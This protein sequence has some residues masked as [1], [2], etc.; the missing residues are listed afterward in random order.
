MKVLVAIDCSPVLER[1]LDEAAGHGQNVASRPARSRLTS[2]PQDGSFRLGQRVGGRRDS[3]PM[4]RRSR[5]E[6]VHAKEDAMLLAKELQVIAQSP[7]P[8][9][10][11][12]VNTRTQNASR[13]PRVPACLAWLRKE[14][15]SISRT[16]R[17]RDAE[18]FLQEVQRIVRFL[19]DRR[20]E[21]K[22]LAI[23]SGPKTWTIFPMHIAVENELAW[24]QPGIGQLFRLLHEHKSC[25][26]VAVDH[27][28]ARF[29]AYS[30]GELTELARK[31]FEVDPS[32]WKKKSLGHV[33]SDR[34][35]KMRGPHPDRFEHRMGTQ[36]ARL[37]HETAEQA[38]TLS[39]QYGLA[40]I[41]LAGPERLIGPMRTK[42]PPIFGRFVCLVSQDLG[43]C[44]PRELLQRLEP[45]IAEYEQ[46][47]QMAA[48]TRLLDTDNGTVVDPDETL[49]QLQ[50]GAVRSVVV[51]RDFELDLRQC[52]KCGLAS[53]AGDPVCAACSG[54]RR[55][56]TLRELLPA[57]LVAHNTGVEIVSG[58]AARML[59]RAGGM[60]G[61]LRQAKVTTAG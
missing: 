56:V 34:I 18:R 4:L 50:N 36:Y 42:F 5:P 60:R 43:N 38:A 49:T 33:T 45:I 20:P 23:F 17:P 44:T 48:V 24:G 15:A 30:L 16:L 10:T 21:E 26:I 37:C 7:A 39:K 12:Y 40:H 59:E 58:E 8:I 35:Q 1:A 53:R 19:H 28:A 27:R 57:L 32:Q 2:S 22:A 25:C 6:V 54:Q 29:F 41:F 52:R 13:H 11:V 55:K 14:A 46:K 31:Q 61:W 3:R 51:S 47:R 9:L